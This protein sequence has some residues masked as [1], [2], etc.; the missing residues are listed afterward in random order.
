MAVGGLFSTEGAYYLLFGL[1]DIGEAPLKSDQAGVI[2]PETLGPQPAKLGFNFETCSF[3]SI[4]FTA[5]RIASAVLAT[6]IPSVHPS[7][8]LSA[9]A[10]IVSKRLHIARCSLHYQIAKCV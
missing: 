3:F 4:F 5:R 1:T 8:C 9:H 7:V 6:A 10:G 2:A